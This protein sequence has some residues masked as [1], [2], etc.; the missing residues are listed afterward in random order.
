MH[1]NPLLLHTSLIALLVHFLF[2]LC[3][4]YMS[5]ASQYGA[6]SVLSVLEK[7]FTYPSYVVC[8]KL[9]SCISRPVSY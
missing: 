1:K 6:I 8:I 7:Q 4:T 2:Q 3:D 9:I 5:V